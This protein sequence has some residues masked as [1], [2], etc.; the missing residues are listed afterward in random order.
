MRVE[1]EGVKKYGWI[2]KIRKVK[3][4]DWRVSKIENYKI[5]TKFSGTKKATEAALIKSILFLL[6]VK[7]QS[8][9]WKRWI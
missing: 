3:S 5:L 8:D 1:G 9:S 6:E 4:S 7:I 2:W